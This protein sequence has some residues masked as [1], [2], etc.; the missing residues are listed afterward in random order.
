MKLIFISDNG[1]HH[2]K[3]KLKLW[4][5]VLLS[6]LIISLVS[7][8]ALVAI[9]KY[10]IINNKNNKIN[11]ISRNEINVL[12]RFN[13]LLTKIASLEAEVQRLHS[14]SNKLASQSDIDIQS[15]NLDKEPARGGIIGTANILE[16][17]I[18]NEQNLLESIENIEH[19]LTQQITRF[20]YLQKLMA[21]KDS[22]MNFD[23]PGFNRQTLDNSTYIKR[24]KYSKS[25]LKPSYSFSS[26]VTT[27]YISSSYGV[28]RDP[29]NGHHKHHDGIDIA[30]KLGNKIHAIASG[31]VTFSGR[32]TGYGKVIE[33]HHSDS[34]KSRYAHLNEIKV[35][36]GMVVRKGTN[37]GTMGKTGRATGP[38]L[39]LEVWENDN[40]VNPESFIKTAL[41]SLK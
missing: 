24:S 40:P 32:K 29:I 38:H 37:I 33:I 15:F 18:I 36:K 27:G 9:E 39:H 34:L 13:L 28:R 3:I 7:F 11:D 20:S 41:K 25:K 26:P 19:R 8:T 31:F 21:N 6:L 22:T 12:N 4:L 35:K 17:E 14:L 1:C 16:S 30:G 23:N 10:K 5:L 2:K